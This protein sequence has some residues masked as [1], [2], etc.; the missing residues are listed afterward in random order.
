MTDLEFAGKISEQIGVMYSD[1]KN[2][3]LTRPEFALSRLRSVTSLCC[4][5]IANTLG[6]GKLPTGLED[7][8]NK[9][10]DGELI[11]HEIRDILHQLRQAGNKGAHPEQYTLSKE[12]FVIIAKESLQL[13]RELLGKIFQIIKNGAALPDYD[14]VE[15]DQ[16]DI[17]ALCYQALMGADPDAMYQV[18]MLL[19]LNA[20]DAMK[21]A[22]EEARAADMPI[23]DATLSYDYQK[24]SMTL[25]RL[26]S[27]REHPAACYECGLAMVQG[28]TFFS[29]DQAMNG[30]NLILS[31][32]RSGDINAIAWVGSAYMRGTDAIEL[33]YNEA[34]THLE[35]AAEHDHPEALC[36][37]AT[38]HYEGLGT[39]IDH[40]LALK[41]SLRAARAGYP[42]AQYNAF[43]LLS[44]GEGNAQNIESAHDWLRRAA[45]AEQPDACLALGGLKRRGELKS[46]GFS[47]IESL[48]LRAQVELNEATYEMAMLYHTQGQT[49]EH[50]ILAMHHLQKCYGKALNEEDER[51]V[52]NC[53]ANSEAIVRSATRLMR[54][55]S[56]M[57]LS[58][59]IQTRLYFDK[60]GHLYPNQNEQLQR[61]HE[62]MKRI[63]SLKGVNDVEYKRQLNELINKVL[64]ET[65][66]LPGIRVPQLPTR[67]IRNS[68]TK[69]GRNDQC[70][71]GSGRKFKAC[72]ANQ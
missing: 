32:S 52:Q 14:V 67:P 13:T 9:L 49:N 44:K 57:E 28:D 16:A 35:R 72:C 51:L 31:A 63:A 18:G 33:D 6:V 36:N 43:V 20:S 47:E 10:D 48:L 40:R 56:D 3:C 29:H 69:I 30:E 62:A 8:I 53:K 11:N 66:A 60:K 34:R 5:A 68:T 37:L 27:D 23:V 1:A 55:M 12:Q 26:A 21:K 64:P 15:I 61:N 25:L 42:L 46:E 24:R 17:Q 71:C 39:P 65:L 41:Y 2:S 45:D 4:D 58:A 38:L 7:K 59:F 19:R 54:S 22:S 50:A 70:H